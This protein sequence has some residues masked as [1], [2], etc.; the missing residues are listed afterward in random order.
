M[1]TQKSID[2]YILDAFIVVVY[3]INYINLFVLIFIEQH[4]KK[5]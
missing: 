1:G 4:E 5:K 3:P 2:S